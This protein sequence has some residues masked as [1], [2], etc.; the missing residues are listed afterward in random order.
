[1]ELVK[2]RIKFGNHVL[3]ILSLFF[4]IK[5]LY[6]SLFDISFSEALNDIASGTLKKLLGDLAL[7]KGFLEDQIDACVSVD[8]Q[9]LYESI[10]DIIDKVSINNFTLGGH[11]LTLRLRN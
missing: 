8:L 2:F 10:V 4:G 1:M 6:H 11:Y 5:P 3:N 7:H 9:S